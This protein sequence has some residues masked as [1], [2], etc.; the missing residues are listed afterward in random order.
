MARILEDEAFP[1]TLSRNGPLVTYGDLP[2]DTSDPS[3]FV[4]ELGPNDPALRAESIAFIQVGKKQ[5]PF[6]IRSIPKTELEQGMA[7]L[8]PPTVYLRNAHGK[9]VRDEQGNRIEVE[10]SPEKTAWYL[11]FG[12]MK[13]LLGLAEITLR[14]RAGA[15][16]WQV[17]GDQ[18]SRDIR[19]AIQ[20]LKDSGIATQHIEDLNKAIDA[21]TTLE[22][23]EAVEDLLGNSDGD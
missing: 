21:L 12:Y 10:D 16:V 5:K 2:P 6:K 18:E 19:A 4:T 13:V 7:L 17:P 1:Q 8:R 14:D 20:A 15:V 9:Y 11:T 22:T 23:D 3:E